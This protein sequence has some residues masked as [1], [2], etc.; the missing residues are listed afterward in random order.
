MTKASQFRAL[1]FIV[2][3]KG[4]IAKKVDGRCSSDLILVTLGCHESP[5]R[6]SK[7]ESPNTKLQC[8][9]PLKGR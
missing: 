6:D 3:I 9:L 8:Y 5:S 4:R 1:D 2:T 7:Q